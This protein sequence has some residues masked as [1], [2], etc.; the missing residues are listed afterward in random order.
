MG[1]KEEK[2]LV[3]TKISWVN[4]KKTVNFFTCGAGL[5]CHKMQVGREVK[6]SEDTKLA[7]R[8]WSFNEN[9]I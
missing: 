4:M 5:K 8:R 9:Y 1:A 6:D 3:D 2:L 7:A